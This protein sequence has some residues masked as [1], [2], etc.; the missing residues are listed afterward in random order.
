[1][2]VARL[3]HIKAT[4]KDSLLSCIALF[5]ATLIAACSVGFIN[6]FSICYNALLV[7]FGESKEKTAWI[8]SIPW[9]LMFLLGPVAS[10]VVNKLGLR[11]STMLASIPLSASLLLTSFMSDLDYM[12]ITFSI[13]F[14]LGASVLLVTSVKVFQPEV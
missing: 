8:G 9:S 11:L 14:G 13:P 3:W 12:F 7:K 2:D 6:I 10:W 4:S 5:A 1:M